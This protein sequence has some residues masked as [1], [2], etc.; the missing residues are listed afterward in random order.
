MLLKL[1]AKGLVTGSLRALP[2]EEEIHR[3]FEALHER[4]G[5]GYARQ[6]FLPRHV[7]ALIRAHHRVDEAVT[8]ETIPAHLMVLTDELCRRLNQDFLTTDTV[9][10]LL[11][12]QK[13]AEIGILMV[14]G[15][16]GSR[17]RQ[18]FA[19]LG[20]FLSAIGIFSGL[21]LG[22][23]IALYLQYNHLDI[24]PSDI[25]YDSHIPSRVS[26]T[27]VVI[28]IVFNKSHKKHLQ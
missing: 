21:V 23:G 15:L 13:R 24:L 18:L 8:P 1:I 26:W 20:V 14:I 6:S 28:D 5:A 7:V 3:V 10:V 9:L 22:T 2:S 19:G 12:S 25:Y 4:A 16:S 17:V 11:I 27:F